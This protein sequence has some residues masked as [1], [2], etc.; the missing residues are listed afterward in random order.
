MAYNEETQSYDEYPDSPF[1]GKIMDNPKMQDLSPMLRPIAEQYNEAWMINDTDTMDS[2]LHQYPNL[3]KTLFNAKKFNI[4]RDNIIALQQFFIDKVKQMIDTIAQHT[5]GIKN[6][7]AAT[8]KETNTYSASKID[9]MTGFTLAENISI[10]ISEWIEAT[11]EDGYKFS[12]TYENESILATDEVGVNF[13]IS[14]LF[15]AGKAF[16]VGDEN[17]VDGKL[18]LYARKLPKIDLIIKSIEVVRK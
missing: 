14:S 17:G 3:E 16:V 11:R 10:P 8:E 13:A 9:E 2:L 1:P 15:N 7:A 18:T 5:I 4:L 6:D 12:W